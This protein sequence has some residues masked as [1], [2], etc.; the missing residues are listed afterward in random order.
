MTLPAEGPTETSARE[1]F[2]PDGPF[3]QDHNRSRGRSWRPAKPQET[4]FE[5]SP[6]CCHGS[7]VKDLIEARSAGPARSIWQRTAREKRRL[8]YFVVG[9][10]WFSLA[11]AAHD[12]DGDVV[13]RFIE[14][15]S[16]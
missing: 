11:I 10:S 4:A 13:A 2:N 16:V 6:T 12:I 7:A 15:D 8:C 9:S 14:E 3:G 1:L 5:R